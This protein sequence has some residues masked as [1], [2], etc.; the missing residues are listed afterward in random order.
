MGGPQPLPLPADRCPFGKPSAEVCTGFRSFTLRPLG[1]DG[2]PLPRLVSCGHLTVGE[3]ADG[4]GF[5]PRCRAGGAAVYLR[6][7]D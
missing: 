4:S 6:A 5:Y 7:P 2:E 1:I 3:L